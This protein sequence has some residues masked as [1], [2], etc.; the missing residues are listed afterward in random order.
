MFRLAVIVL[1]VLFAAPALAEEAPPVE[2]AQDTLA[3]ALFGGTWK[4]DLRVRYEYVD[5]DGFADSHAQT[6]RLRLGYGTKPLS[7]L[8][9]F[10]E[11]EVV[12]PL[13][14]DDSYNGA[15][16][17]SEGAHAVV[18]DPESYEINQAYGK[19][20]RDGLT[21][22]AGR[23]RIILDDARFVGNVGWRQ[24]EQ[25]FDAATI[26]YTG[27]ENWD[28]YYGHIWNVR[29]IFGSDG[30]EASRDFDNAAAHI[31]N[32]SYDGFSIGKLTG[33]VYLFDF[34]S[35]AA[36]LKPS[37]PL[38]SNTFGFRLAGK[39]PVTE[40]VKFGYILSY[41][42]QVDA[43]SNPMNYEADYFLADLSAT[44]HGLTLGGG[45]EML[46]SDDGMIAFSTPLATGH[47]FNGWADVFL[48]TPAIGLEDYYL[49]ASGKLPWEVKAKVVY[50]WFRGEDVSADLG[51]ELDVLF[52]RAINEHVSVTAKF[53]EY[54]GGPAGS[55]RTKL[56]LQID[57][58][59]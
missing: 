37:G 35:P 21:I 38:S 20:D 27:F 51:E 4:M 36:P 15:G 32:V 52:T 11:G 44:C 40:N 9:A 50:H 57:V 31:F 46:G 45:Y 34:E 42:H 33:F 53:S 47:K 14:N 13:F 43:D 17:N 19:F 59:F 24:N 6:G 30:R 18:A 54:W 29:R 26:R 58:K 55:D 12:V 25:T 3:D 5:Q 10:I 49:Y 28:L 16:L 2:P 23:Q 41:A 7:G 1:A 8:S 48:T 22:I 39:Q 56:W